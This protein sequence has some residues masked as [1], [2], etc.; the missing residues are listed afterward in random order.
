MSQRSAPIQSARSIPYPYTP[1]KPKLPTNDAA[2]RR[3]RRRRLASRC[4]RDGDTRQS[5][6][7]PGLQPGPWPGRGASP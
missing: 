2:V 3:T 7:S 6:P 5:N 1:K 4:K